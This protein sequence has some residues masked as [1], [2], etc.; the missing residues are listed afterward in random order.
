[1]AIL[2][3][4]MLGGFA[5]AWDDRVELSIPGTATR[6]LLAYLLVH[7]DRSHSRNLLAGLFWPD[8]PDAVARRRLTQA[9]W[10][11]RAA[12]APHPALLTEG[13]A[14]RLDPVL[15][16][17]LDV[18]EF[19]RWVDEE[20]RRAVDLYRGEFLAG[21]YDD[22]LLA[23]RER[24]REMFL[25]A[26][27]RLVAESKARG[28]VEEALAHACRLVAEDPWREEAHCEVM[29]LCHVLG[30]DAEALKQYY[31]C[32]QALAD[33]LGIEP[34][35]ATQALAAEI[36][37]RAGL[38]ELPWTP[39]AARPGMG[40]LLE[41][42]DRLPLVG[43]K[44]ELAELLSQLD[45]IAQG[46][47]GLTLVVGE[48]GVGK[49]R[50]LQELARNARWR[51]FRCAW[52]H[53][54]E[55]AGSPAYQPLVE[56]LRA[57]LPAL[58]QPALEPLWRVELARL[59]PELAGGEPLPALDPEQEQRR[60]LEAIARGFAA[61]AA[62]APCL[63]LLEDAH[64]MD[65]ASLLAIRMMLPHLDRMP[66]RIVLT[67]RSED[68]DG[69]QAAALAEFESTRLLHRIDL[70][71]LD[72]DE[73]AELV[74]RA[75]DLA[76]PPP[77]FAARLYAET[78]GN[79]FFVTE[80]LR[81][82][83]EEKLLYR[84]QHGEWSTAWDESTQDYGELPLP[85][86]VA[87]SIGRRLDRLPALLRDS[88]G[89]ASVIG[90]Q[91]R[92]DVWLHAGDLAERELLAA[93]D[94]L[95]RRG[96]LI[97]SAAGEGADYT[98]AHDH[99]R[100][101]TYERLTPPRRRFVHRRVAQA[102]ADLGSDAPAALAYHWSEAQV[103]D[104]AA[105]CHQQAGERAGL[106]YANASAAAHY[107]QALEALARMPGPPDLA[108]Q[109][110][111]R[112]AREQAYDLQGARQEQ[113][114]E[115]AA[116]AQLAE[117]LDDDRRR[118][119]VALRQARQAAFTSDY[120]TAID[121]ASRAARLAQDAQ[122]VTIEASSFW[123]WG[124]ALLLLGD[125]AAAQAQFHRS[126]ALARAANMRSLEADALHGL[127]TVCLVTC[128]YAQAKGFFEQVLHIG[129]Q[130]DIRQRVGRSLSNL[131]YIATA[132][133]DHAASKAYNEQALRI[134]CEI[135][136]QKGAAVAL[137]HLGDELLA[138]GD[139]AAA[140]DC[141]EAALTTQQAVRARENAGVTLRSLGLLYHQLGDA[142]RAGECYRQ[143]ME[144]FDDSGIRWYQGQTWAYLSLLSHHLGDDQ[145]ARAQSRRGLEIAEEIGDRLALGWLL[146]ALGH[147]LAGLGDL[148]GAA[149]AYRR[150]LAVRR[151]LEQAHLAAES[152][153]GLA[154]V[155][156]AQGSVAQAG[157]YV[158]D[159]LHIER[160]SGLDGSNEPFRIYLTC[161]QVLAAC[162]DRRAEEIL[163][164]AYE[165]W[166]EQRAHIPEADLQRSFLENVAA[167]REL[168]ATYHEQ[169]AR[170]QVR[171]PRKGAPLRRAL[172]DEETVDVTWTVSAPED[173]AVHGKAARRQQR[174]VRLL[175][176]AAEQG[177]APTVDDLAQALGASVATIK[178]DLATLR[179]GGEEVQ[180]R[181][182]RSAQE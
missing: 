75:L 103:W 67:V 168:V 178:R 151:E 7:R 40:A 158:E 108:R 159:I 157:E 109:F 134:Y 132:Q 58:S 43:R 176:E 166:Q 90:R 37:A 44:A 82:L 133:G 149:A 142:A 9:L 61:L 117:E 138:A 25:A 23:E 63:V 18:E 53:C 59:L 115:L 32:R 162:E 141:L 84:D 111:L 102:L 34:S 83:V 33:E 105:D 87:Q 169:R 155:A 8:L 96:L 35:P 136:D 163:G 68:L 174:L 80:M 114:Q 127:G 28:A 122:D 128:D 173:E 164:A 74:Q 76:Q 181:G 101:V 62:A 172:R 47:G 55:L 51:G 41:H 179:Q 144:I 4:R 81:A 73:T 145:A 1:M 153:A 88:L 118:A 129:S 27:E 10:Q 54:S 17:W 2:H 130:V 22:W 6:S 107:T 36:A 126:L 93:G 113:A 165:R 124:W 50:L 13:D 49:T 94:E 100:R 106:V 91:V 123:E 72:L 99:I 112:L 170:C 45:A 95:C 98:F 180:T 116:L 150:A 69:A 131:G 171:L 21:Y 24:L 120:P 19:G 71:R 85:G 57:D 89:L 38:S 29:R 60:L 110:A 48:A 79:P 175:R 64:W 104:R 14:V 65:L 125:H 143:A 154:R 26:L 135:G 137:Q 156:L 139:F 97:P 160:S 161:Y 92:F 86:S 39:A 66:L 56:A 70:R 16:L 167:N 46:E 31:L 121:A 146:D 177:A 152:L 12:L 42:P 20:P 3:V 5:L 140:R 148:D 15:P 182:S 52:G 147:A 78:E 77:R 11:I 119:V 30:R